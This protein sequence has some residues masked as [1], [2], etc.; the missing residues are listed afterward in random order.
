MKKNLFKIISCILLI[1]A[2]IVISITVKPLHILIDNLETENSNKYINDVSTKHTLIY[3]GVENTDDL[4]MNDNKLAVKDF[5]VNTDIS[6][7]VEYKYESINNVENLVFYNNIIGSLSTKS[8]SFI[9][10]DRIGQVVY[11]FEENA[12]IEEIKSFL[13]E[14]FAKFV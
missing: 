13:K 11:V 3:L 10:L 2:T 6:K 4:N 9:L 8:N 14:Y 5:L 1:I 7:Y 12:D